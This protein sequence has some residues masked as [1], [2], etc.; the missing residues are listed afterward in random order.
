MTGTDRPHRAASL[1]VRLRVLSLGAGVQSTTLALMASHGEIGPMPDCAIFADTQAEPLS[2]YSHLA[3][4]TAQL[5]FPV[6]IVTAGSLKDDLVRGT[7][8]PTGRRVR[9]APTGRTTRGGK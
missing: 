4:L 6:D 8:V 2:V 9:F 1:P 7:I 3:R 5:P